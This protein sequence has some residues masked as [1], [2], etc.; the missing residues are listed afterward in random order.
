M[1]EPTDP[2]D[3]RAASAE[4]GGE[5]LH[6]KLFDAPEPRS[7]ARLP[8]LG[9]QPPMPPAVGADQTDL[10]QPVHAAPIQGESPSAQQMPPVFGETPEPS[11]RESQWGGEALEA[12]RSGGTWIKPP[13]RTGEH[14]AAPLAGGYGNGTPTGGAQP[15]GPARRV[16]PKPIR[17]PKFS[18]GPLVAGFGLLSILL[19]VAIMAFMAVKVLDG[20]GSGTSGNNDSPTLPDSIAPGNPTSEEGGLSGTG[21]SSASSA[22]ACGVDQRTIA[23]AAAAYSV[24]NGS[25]PTS[26]DQLVAADLLKENP[27]TFTL[28]SGIEGVRVVGIGVCEGT[29]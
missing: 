9:V 10:G 27:K 5:E 3:A 17:G 14:R 4:S 28:E 11:P 1:A 29:N 19:V 2:E 23:T 6:P 24:M 18:G 21:A 16:G 12:E 20:T 22:A 7:G 13:E 8:P 15:G 26:V 25:D